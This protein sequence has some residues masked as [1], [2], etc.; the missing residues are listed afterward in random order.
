M[1][2]GEIKNQ[3]NDFGKIHHRKVTEAAKKQL[4][5]LWHTTNIY[6]HP[7]IHEYAEKLV[8]TL[9]GDLKVPSIIH[10]FC[11]FSKLHSHSCVPQ[12]V[13]YFVNSGSEANDLAMMMARLHTG[14]YDLISFRNAY[15]GMSPYTNGLTAHSTWRFNIAGNFGI[16]QVRNEAFFSF[17]F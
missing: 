13:V 12:Q 8:A 9:P 2:I 4:D 16:H 7:K 15:H 5:T 3:I 1:I 11:P 10:A 6:L 17:G 14:T